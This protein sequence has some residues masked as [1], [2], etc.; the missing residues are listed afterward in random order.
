MGF[1]AKSGASHN[2]I[3]VVLVQKLGLKRVMVEG[4]QVSNNHGPKLLTVVEPNGIGPKML[5]K[6]G[7]LGELHIEIW[8]ALKQLIRC[9]KIYNLVEFHLEDKVSFRGGVMIGS[10]SKRLIKGEVELGMGL[11]REE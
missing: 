10:Q 1:S 8:Q 9:W 3:A 11:G 7:D 5:N 4:Q 2:F 6:D